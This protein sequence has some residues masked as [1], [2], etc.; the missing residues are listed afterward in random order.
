MPRIGGEANGDGVQ[1]VVSRCVYLNIWRSSEKMPVGL[2]AGDATKSR[3]Y[4]HLRTLVQQGY[5][6]QGAD[7]ECHRV[8]T[9][10]TTLGA[11]VA[12]ELRSD[13]RQP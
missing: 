1:A 4:R 13:P 11:S 8:E 5:I 12:A 7:T 2:G 3:I 10:P 6:Q 9:R